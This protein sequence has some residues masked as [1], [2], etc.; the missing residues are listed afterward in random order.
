VEDNAS[1]IKERRSEK[2]IGR[3]EDGGR[4]GGQGETLVCSVERQ[5]RRT[6]VGGHEG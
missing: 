2:K 3:E 1:G 5:T 4:G 6:F